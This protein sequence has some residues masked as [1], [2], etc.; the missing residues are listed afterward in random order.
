LLLD[1]MFGSLIV[2]RFDDSVIA[3]FEGLP[4]TLPSPPPKGGGEERLFF[5]LPHAVGERAG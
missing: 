4:L 1:E 2:M 3:S 5:P